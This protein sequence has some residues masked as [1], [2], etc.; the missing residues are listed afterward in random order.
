MGS[1]SWTILLLA[2]M[3]WCLVAVGVAYL[4]GRFIGS[5]DTQEDGEEAGPLIV[6]YY[7]RRSRGARAVPALRAPARTKRRV[8]SG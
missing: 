1:M 7:R 4:F 5:I 3:G 2:L 6:R 8:S